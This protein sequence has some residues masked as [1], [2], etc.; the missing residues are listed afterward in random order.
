M[1]LLDSDSRIKATVIILFILVVLLTGCFKYIRIENNETF[2]AIS[3][4]NSHSVINTSPKF[5]EVYIFENLESYKK[6]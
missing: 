2:G 4:L 6:Y 1:K 5:N 3:T